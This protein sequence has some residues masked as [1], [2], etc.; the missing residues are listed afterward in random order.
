MCHTDFRLFEVLAAS[1]STLLTSISTMKRRIILFAVGLV[2][3]F[4]CHI[5]IKFTGSDAMSFASSAFVYPPSPKGNQV[6]QYHG[7]SIA[8]PYRWLEDPDSP[9]TKAWVEAQNKL[10][11]G[12]LAQIPERT[13]HTE[14]TDRSAH[15]AARSQLPFCRWHCCPVWVSR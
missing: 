10:T 8:D 12:F 3:A 7:V 5:G 11:F 4:I 1:R 6:D 15:C 14:V 13:L 9:E 2:F